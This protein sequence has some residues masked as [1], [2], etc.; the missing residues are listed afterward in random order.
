MR[1]ARHGFVCE[2]RCALTI[3]LENVPALYWVG[4]AIQNFYFEKIRV[5]K[6]GVCYEYISME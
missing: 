6:A 2:C 5:F 4:F 1:L 3:L